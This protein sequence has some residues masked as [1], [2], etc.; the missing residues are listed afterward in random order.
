MEK[1]RIGGVIVSDLNHTNYGSCLQA[2]ATSRM[3]Q[4]MGYDLTF[5]K[6]KKQRSILDWLRIGP[7]LVFSGGLEL[8][9]LKKKRKDD[10]LRYPGYLS[11]QEIREKATNE[12]KLK[13]FVPFFKEYVGF[14]ALCKGS[15]EFDAVFVGSDQVWRP[16]GFY[17]YYWNLLFVDDNVPKFSYA[18]SYGVSKIPWIQRKGTKKYLE[19]LDLISVREEKAKDIV[20]SISNKKAQVVADPTMLLTPEEWLS[21][22]EKSNTIIPDEPYI[23]CYF[24]GPRPDIRKEALKLA[25]KTG[26]KIVIMRHMDEY[27]PIEETLGDY[28]PYDVDARDFVKLLSKA[29]YVLTDSFHGS[30]FSILTCRKFITFYRL[31]PSSKQSTHSRID[32]LL[33]KFGLINRKFDGDVLQVMNEIDYIKVHEILTN[34][35]LESI[36]FLKKALNLSH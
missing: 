1:K 23:F 33:D 2:Y 21:F 34:Y 11:N 6:Y 14:P 7:K 27:V 30:V 22:S 12:F 18:A 35:R 26:L 8:L 36:D 3:I 31:K 25:K 9:R 4:G 13:E 28:A 20:E 15:K 19:R 10:I 16:F 29:Q 32:N 17:S 5:I 24:L